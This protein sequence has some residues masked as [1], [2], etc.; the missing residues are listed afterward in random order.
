[1]RKIICLILF[2][3]IA[4]FG[5]TAPSNQ[6]F[7][8][9]MA[10]CDNMG[11]YVQSA[12]R[13]SAMG[14]PLAAAKE[15]AAG[16]MNKNLK[17]D[18]DVKAG[19]I[20][21]AME[22]YSHVYSTP[23]GKAEQVDIVLS[24]TCGK[25]RGYDLSQEQVDKYLS[26]TAQSAWNPLVRV[27]LCTKVAQSAANIGTARDKGLSREKLGEVARTALRED[28]FTLA[29][30]P[31]LIDEAYDNRAAEVE[32]LYVYN[33]G[34]CNA[35]QHAVDYPSLSVLGPEFSK[36]KAVSSQGLESIKECHKRVFKVDVDGI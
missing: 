30:L 31:R 16:L 6:H 23:S 28:K 24:K 20:A 34:R 5:Q 26:T 2:I 14:M 4:G 7:A 35:K 21:L 11:M 9:A 17:I 13:Q 12:Q 27:P 29:E 19:A 36:C 33:L 18:N 3:S 22:I 1:M 15:L 10:V 8:E 25:Y 32:F